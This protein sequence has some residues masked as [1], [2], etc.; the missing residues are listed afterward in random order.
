MKKWVIIPVLLFS[1]T[2]GRKEPEINFTAARATEYFNSIDSICRNDNGKLWG[3]NIAGPV[4][5]VDRPTRRIFASQPDKEGL[6]KMKDGVFQGIFPRER[7]IENAPVEY[8]GEIY[9]M[10]PLPRQDDRYR[11][12][13]QAV[14]ALFRRYLK[15]KSFEPERY[16]IHNWD[17]K[18]SRVWLKL[19][20]KALRK[21][22][23]SDY[24]QLTNYLRDA[25]IFRS[26][27]REQ[28]KGSQAD[29]NRLEKYNGLSL[30]TSVVLCNESEEKASTRMTESLDFFYSF[31]S[32][33]RSA[34][35]I[36]GAVYGYLLYRNGFDLKSILLNKSGL[37]SAVISY[38]RLE[39]PEISRDVAGSLAIVYDVDAIYK[40]EAGRMADIRER[41]RRQ[42]SKFT[43]KPVLTLE[44]ESPNFD[45][46]PEDIRPLDTLGTI[47]N[48]LRV[49]DNWGKLTVEKGGCLLTNNLKTIRLGAK[50]LKE[51]KN[52][53]Y[54]DG[55]Q[56]ILNGNWKVVREDDNYLLRKTS[57]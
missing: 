17:E 37:D 30:F 42:L 31:P 2:C 53:I 41:V 24:D 33:S 23:E 1:V 13:T 39:M 19:E 16:F 9:A 7:I 51:S 38:F 45:F 36:L 6:L 50:T 15:S 55:W 46:E 35:T 20:Y 5:F 40:E 8:G 25:V 27:R 47:Y 43:E 48:A 56:L 57:F 52:H 26:A 18:S 44:L 28:I 14:S 34:G 11:I 22:L 10:I 21:A 12:I 4:M 3:V 49:S 29:E 54:G 32:F